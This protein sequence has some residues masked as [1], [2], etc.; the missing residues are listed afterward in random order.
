M[1]QASW[2]E[3]FAPRGGP[4]VVVAE[5]P[6]EPVG[7]RRLFWWED[8]V[9]FAIVAA[10]MLAVVASIQLAGWVDEMPPL[11]PISLLGLLMGT[12]FARVRW[13]EGFIHL[14]ALPIGAA[15]ILGQLIG[16]MSGATP[17][18]RYWELHHRMG[19]WFH[20]AFTGGISNDELPFI[21]LVV[22]L[23]WLAS[24]WCAW[25]VFRWHNAWL[26]LLPAGGALAANFGLQT[27][28]FSLSFLVFLFGGA[29]LLTRLHLL[30]RSKSWRTEETPYPPYLS[31]SV[32]HATFWL[33]LALLAVAWLMPRADESTALD[34]LWDS[35]TAPVEARM[36]K[37][38]RLFVSVDAKKSVRIHDFQDILP[39]LGNVD[40]SNA[41]ALEI[42]AGKLD[43]QG[44][45]RAQSYAIY[46]PEGW[47][48]GDYNASEL[49]GEGTSVDQDIAAR[50]DVTIQV[51]N[52]GEAGSSIFTL[53]QPISSDVSARLQWLE[54]QQNVTGLQSQSEVDTG[55][56][57]NST[58]SVSVATEEQ[59]RAAGTSYPY[60]VRQRYLQ[61]PAKFPERIRSLANGISLIY[62]VAPQFYPT[63]E[64]ETPTPYDEAVAIQ[65]YLREFPYDITVPDPPRGADAM[66]YFLFDAKRGYF[67]FHASAMVVMLRSLGVPARLAVGYVID[68]PAEDG[69]VFRYQITEQNA[70]AWPEVYFPGLGW[71]EF[72]PTP[73]RPAIERPGGTGFGTGVDGGVDPSVAPDLGF[74]GL[75]GLFPTPE[76][77]GP[78]V[79]VAPAG[80]SGNTMR[81][82][83]FGLLGG[84]TTLAVVATGGAGYAWRRGLS[85]L[86]PP[87]RLWEQTIRLA[88][89]TRLPALESLTPREYARVLHAEAGADGVEALAEAYVRHRF[90][91]ARAGEAEAQRL[92][93]TWRSVRNVMLRRLWPL[94]RRGAG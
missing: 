58:G 86:E 39:F 92:E 46:T 78:D 88:S 42:L 37:I 22:S 77:T 48:L 82:V 93:L 6:Q 1:R 90:G 69:E 38:S 3:I 7:W 28:Q 53:G 76:E 60:W 79:S 12:L 62:C 61:L 45:L 32:M 14:I 2:N 80:S 19:E 74:G 11:V 30:E 81:F 56:R 4:S 35:A 70:Y 66:E 20:A 33:A 94:G 21:L 15:G 71:V 72:N 17:W 85:R 29:L 9:T 55:G 67:D 13:P 73:D 75:G 57:Y 52:R 47:R 25:A 84:L 51:I 65:D 31:L 27:A 16:I 54:T 64:S 68:P 10:I 8:L 91:G 44:Y 59:L 40:L 34:G 41:A 83:L 18:A 87:A 23:C 89:W 36:E 24:Y 50:E 49:S 63:C 43:Q 5:V 26:A